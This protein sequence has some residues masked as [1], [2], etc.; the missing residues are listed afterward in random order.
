[1]QMLV[2]HAHDDEALQLCET[3]EYL[4]FTLLRI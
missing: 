2:V 4:F 1:M 3:V